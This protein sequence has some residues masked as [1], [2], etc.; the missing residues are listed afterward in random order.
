MCVRVVDILARSPLL[1][2]HVGACA[3]TN[4]S[5]NAQPKP[6]EVV[7]LQQSHLQHRFLVLLVWGDIISW[8]PKFFRPLLS[9]VLFLALTDKPIRGQPPP[10]VRA[11]SGE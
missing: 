10:G 11:P 5:V 3:T 9:C 2:N 4:T 6:C 7:S 1:A 8:T